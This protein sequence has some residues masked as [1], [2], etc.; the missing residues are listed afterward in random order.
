MTSIAKALVMLMCAAFV[1]SLS[2]VVARAQEGRRARA[3]SAIENA[4][5]ALPSASAE[6]FIR[7]A[8]YYWR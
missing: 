3:V 1:V 7:A 2:I 5:R 4:T 6:D 8:G